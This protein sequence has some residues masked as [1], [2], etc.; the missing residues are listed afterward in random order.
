M[1]HAAWITLGK[2]G[3]QLLLKHVLQGVVGWDELPQFL[4]KVDIIRHASY[5]TTFVCIYEPS[6]VNKVV[7]SALKFPRL[8]FIF[9]LS[10]FL[11]SFSSQGAA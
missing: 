6:G 8:C 7:E 5:F 2:K 1:N 9:C 11:P 4:S 3:E 10:E